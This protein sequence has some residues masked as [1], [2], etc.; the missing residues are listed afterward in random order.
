LVWAMGKYFLTIKKNTMEHLISFLEAF[1]PLAEGKRIAHQSWSN[2]EFVF[3]RPADVLPQ[4]IVQR[5][6]SIPAT[7]KA[8]LADKGDIPVT[9]YR[10]YWDGETLWN[11]F[12]SAL[13]EPDTLAK[14]WKVL[15]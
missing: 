4:A 1:T 2:G 6:I 14:V 13:Y 9:A 15:D 10:C 3:E 5:A 7:V 11:G 12:S 8:A